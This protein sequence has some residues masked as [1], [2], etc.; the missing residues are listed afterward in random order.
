MNTY[1]G[2]SLRN[3]ITAAFGSLTAVTVSILFS[4]T[5]LIGSIAPANAETSAQARTSFIVPLA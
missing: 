1:N 4:A 5:C 2:Y 3:S